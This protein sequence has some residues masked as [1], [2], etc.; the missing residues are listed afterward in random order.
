MG[1]LAG[2]GYKAKIT[3]NGSGSG[4]SNHQYPITMSSGTGSNTGS[5]IYTNGHCT[6]YPNDIRFTDDSGNL[7]YFANDRYNTNKFWVK[8]TLPAS[9]STVDIW[10][11]YGHATD[12]DGSDYDN[13]FLFG[14]DFLGS[15]LSGSKWADNNYPAT[16]TVSNSKVH[17]TN[18]LFNFIDSAGGVDSGL[19]PNHAVD[20]NCYVEME[21][22]ISNVTNNKGG[23]IGVGFADASSGMNIFVDAVD[24]EPASAALKYGSTRNFVWTTH[25]TGDSSIQDGTNDVKRL[26]YIKKVGNTFTVGD[27]ALGDFCSATTTYYDHIEIACAYYYTSYWFDKCD[28]EMFRIRDYL[29]SEPSNS[30]GTETACGG[31]GA[32]PKYQMIFIG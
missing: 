13:T 18:C 27:F 24:I 10:V 26:M 12:G 9:A 31:G 2:Y 32:V 28:I 16:Y 7:L 4:V 29:A 23:Q 5:V 11:Y 30:P 14:D 21:V 25:K 20:T 22:I 1:D 6:S 15:S 8:V 17:I 3:I 19:K